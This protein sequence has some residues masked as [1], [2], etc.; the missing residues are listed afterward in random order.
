MTTEET[1]KKV[2]QEIEQGK[3]SMHSKSYFVMR[4]ILSVLGIVILTLSS[5]FTASFIIFCLQL[6]G[7][8]L[9]PGM[10]IGGF[11]DLLLSLPS[12]II[13]LVLLFSVVLWYFSRQYSFTY[14]RPLAY[15][16]LGIIGLV[17]VGGFVVARTPLHMV[18][19]KKY[20][21]PDRPAGI[22]H[23]VYGG[24]G[25]EPLKNGV[26]GEVVTIKQN[27]VQIVTM[28]RNYC[29]VEFTDDTEFPADNN[30]LVGDWL[31]ARGLISKT[32]ISAYA[33]RKINPKDFELEQMPPLM[34]AENNGQ[35]NL[36]YSCA[37]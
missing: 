16:L 25:R 21:R 37:R 11:R 7:A 20:G 13:L 36:T 15:S 3:V 33:V 35:V 8:W 2:M 30:F 10:G 29:N 12:L 26:I 34:P 31:I 17:L 18:F 9:L 14:R 23:K 22:M 1:T 27:G 4:G 5:I 28:F 19:Y 6:R 32:S 24:Y